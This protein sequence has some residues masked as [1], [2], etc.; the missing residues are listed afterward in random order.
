[1]TA[2]AFISVGI[3]LI[4]AALFIAENSALGGTPSDWATP[5]VIVGVANLLCGVLGGI[6]ESLTWS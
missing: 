5:I 4:A 1:M 2:I 3:A 6:L